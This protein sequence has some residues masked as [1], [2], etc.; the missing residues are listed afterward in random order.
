MAKPGYC[1]TKY[2]TQSIL[3]AIFDPETCAINTGADGPVVIESSCEEPV[4]TNICNWDDMPIG[5]EASLAPVGCTK[6]EDGE[7]TGKVFVCKTVVDEVDGTI[8][9]AL[10]HIA[11][12][13]TVTEDWE[14]EWEDCV[15]KEKCTG[16]PT[17]FQKKEYYFGLENT[18][19]RFNR[20]YEVEITLNNGEVRTVTLPAASGWGPQMIAWE[21]ALA[22]AFPELCE[23]ARHWADWKPSQLP[24]SGAGAIPQT[25]MVSG[26]NTLSPLVGQYIQFTACA[27]ELPF[28]P[29]DATFTKV[30]G[31]PFVRGMRY[32]V[33]TGPTEFEA[34]CLSCDE[35]CNEE[36]GKCFIPASAEL[37]TPPVPVCTYDTFT[38]CD[39]GTDPNTTILVTVAICD[40]VQE[41][42]YSTLDEE[43]NSTDYTL[44][45][46]LVDCA[47]GEPVVIPE[48]DCSLELCD[49]AT[50]CTDFVATD[51]VEELKA[52]GAVESTV[53]IVPDTLAGRGDFGNPQYLPN[54][55]GSTLATIDQNLIVPAINP[56]C[57]R[58]DFGTIIINPNVPADAVNNYFEIEITGVDTT[59]GWG[60]VRAHC[61]TT[62]Q[63]FNLS[64]VS[65]TPSSNN[66][67]QT[68]VYGVNHPGCNPEDMRI[69]IAAFGTQSRLN[70]P[71][72]CDEV[73]VGETTYLSNVLEE[74]KTPA[75][76]VSDCSTQET[77]ALLQQ[78][79]IA[80]NT[81]NSQ[82]AELCGKI[83][84]LIGS[85]DDE[86]P[87]EDEEEDCCTNKITTVS[88]TTIVI[89]PGIDG[90]SNG[91]TF[92]I[93][94]E[95]C[96]VLGEATVTAV[97]GSVKFGIKT[98]V[99]LAVGM[100]VRLA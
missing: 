73:G 61:V 33:V 27:D 16:I 59:A 25:D 35:E 28:L 91:D 77:N 50:T 78:L 3:N 12:D 53:L 24:Q 41:V 18:G 37:P 5:I 32:A 56:S 67:P 63:F 96:N 15:P 49:F 10:K 9:Y 75:L 40:G 43:G 38:A 22:A 48:P 83:E 57:E 45:G 36:P 14:G 42:S 62:G 71:D 86:C 100:C 51:D 20:E 68:T 64:V 81:T 52:Q 87:C 39:D 29:V 76:Q 31:N 1:S 95:D 47:T 46:E 7:L 19:T 90:V 85:D 88:G 98:E 60:P 69:T 13:G 30:N 2:S 6:D 58:D 94:D 8:T 89:E 93:L 79:L 92:E 99:K 23:V 44:V 82:L 66:N 65:G 17:M 80:Q 4:F 74:I 54:T 97:G 21:G 84:D 11:T 34:F 70:D 26:N 72:R 55:Y